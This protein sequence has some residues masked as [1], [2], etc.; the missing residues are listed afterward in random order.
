MPCRTYPESIGHA[1][2]EIVQKKTLGRLYLLLIK[3]MFDIASRLRDGPVM[4]PYLK[5]ISMTV[6]R[7]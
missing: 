7:A 2:T 1:K 3:K 6:L 4:P 5:I